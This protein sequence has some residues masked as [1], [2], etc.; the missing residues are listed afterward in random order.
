MSEARRWYIVAKRPAAVA[1]R[2]YEPGECWR[3]Y[4]GR[5]RSWRDAGRA[6]GHL[7]GYV[8]G[9]GENSGWAVTTCPAAFREVK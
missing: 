4:K 6:W 3:T 5:V 2:T 1:G 8:Q 7:R 9:L